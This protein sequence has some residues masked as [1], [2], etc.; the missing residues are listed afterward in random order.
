MELSEQIRKAR[1]DKGIKQSEMAKMLDIERS[2]Y[3]RFENRGTKLTLEQLEKIAYVLGMTIIELLQYGKEEIKKTSNEDITLSNKNLENEVKELETL[4]DLYKRQN[5][6][7]F[8]NLQDTVQAIDKACTTIAVELWGDDLKYH[9]PES[10]KDYHELED[11]LRNRYK[12]LFLMICYLKQLKA[13]EVEDFPFL[14]IVSLLK[15]ED[16][17][18]IVTFHNI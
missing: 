2:N 8:E 13:I 1:E 5:K 4:L 18:D 10:E 12:P 11:Y 9:V 14:K 15:G 3:H 16:F 6:I 7:Y 17:E